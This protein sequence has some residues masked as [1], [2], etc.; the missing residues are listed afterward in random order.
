MAWKTLL[1]PVVCLRM[2]PGLTGASVPVLDVAETPGDLGGGV[3]PPVVTVRCHLVAG[4]DC[5][6]PY[7]P[8]PEFSAVWFQLL[9]FSQRGPRRLW[10]STALHPLSRTISS[11]VSWAEPWG[12]EAVPPLAR[13]A[14]GP[15]LSGMEGASA[16][17]PG[18]GSWAASP[19]PSVVRVDSSTPSV[20]AEG[21]A[22][23]VE[24]VTAAAAPMVLS[25]RGVNWLSGTI[26]LSR[27]G[28]TWPW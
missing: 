7:A 20:R 11:A 16:S 4:S 24:T 25:R 12:S 19:C 13:G 3:G 10:N 18:W 26:A 9:S 2:V 1:I 28:T 17:G 15:G 5:G 8:V 23:S 6:M 21:L 14:E 27:G 22:A